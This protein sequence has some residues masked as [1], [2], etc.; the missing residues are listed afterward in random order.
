MKRTIVL[1]LVLLVSLEAI[2]AQPKKIIENTFLD[3]TDV[4]IAQLKKAESDNSSLEDFKYQ[5]K[6]Y[7]KENELEK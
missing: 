5:Q 4:S 3:I 6:I 1:C 7:A 2:F